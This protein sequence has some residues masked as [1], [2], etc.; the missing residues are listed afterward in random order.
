M[1]KLTASEIDIEE[2]EI[3]VCGKKQ[4]LPLTTTKIMSDCRKG[5][6]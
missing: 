3:G 6:V 5:S 2:E 4:P 1:V